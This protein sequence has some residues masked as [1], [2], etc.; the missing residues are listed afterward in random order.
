MYKLSCDML[1][2]M[3]SL[4]WRYSACSVSCQNK[5]LN[6]NGIQHLHVFQEQVIAGCMLC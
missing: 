2:P 5:L 1:L 4:D 6:S 3:R